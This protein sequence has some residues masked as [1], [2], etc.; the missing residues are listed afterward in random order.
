MCAFDVDTY[1]LYF[2][3]IGIWFGSSNPVTGSNPAFS[4][5]SGYSYRPLQDLGS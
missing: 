2:G 4:I 3:K 5:T 1:K